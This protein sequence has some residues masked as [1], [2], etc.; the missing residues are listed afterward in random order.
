[1]VSVEFIDWGLI[2]YEEAWKRQT[3]LFDALIAAKISGG[4]YKNQV[5]FCEH[6]NVYTLGKSGKE[7]NMLLGEE[8]LKAIQATL[9]HIDRG[10]DITYHGPGQLVC[11]PILNLED[12]NLGLKEYIHLLEEAVI[13]VC[14]HYGVV[15]G[16]LEKATGV[17]LDVGTPRARKICAIGVRSS[18]FVTMHGLALNLN[19]DLRYFS[20][21]NP[22]GFMDKGVTSLQKE[23]NKE[24]ERH[25]VIKLLENEIKSLLKYKQIDL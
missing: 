23:L 2:S 13:R 20:Y 16:R 10:G 17:W 11:Y 19:T 5:V 21:I 14:A 22:C 6:P 7:N 3:E 25:E 4:V 1:M 9:Y 18:R 15:A 24:A 12:F 8:Q